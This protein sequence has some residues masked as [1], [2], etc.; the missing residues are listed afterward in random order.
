[1]FAGNAPN[2][3]KPQIEDPLPQRD[4]MHIITKF[5]AF[6]YSDYYH[7]HYHYH[8]NNNSPDNRIF[9][10]SLCQMKKVNDKIYGTL[11][12]GW[13]AF[14]NT[15]PSSAN[16]GRWRSAKFV[17]LFASKSMSAATQ[18]GVKMQTMWRLPDT[19]CDSLLDSLAIGSSCAPMAF[20]DPQAELIPKMSNMLSVNLWRGL[21]AAESL[22]ICF[23]WRFYPPR[24]SPQRKGLHGLEVVYA[25]SHINPHW[26]SSSW[27]SRGTPSGRRWEH[28]PH[29]EHIVSFWSFFIPI[30]PKAKDAWKVLIL[31]VDRAFSIIF[32]EFIFRDLLLNWLLC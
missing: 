21:A 11:L 31:T 32:W 24:V 15:C 4:K 7:Y 9:E 30:N 27:S 5:V 13:F 25:L 17:S 18:L 2:M 1:M 23:L 10:V 3:A 29:I 26:D 22:M 12:V 14:I 8:H 28:Q 19:K 20:L 16:R 6:L